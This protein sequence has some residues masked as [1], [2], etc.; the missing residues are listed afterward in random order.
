MSALRFEPVTAQ[1]HALVRAAAAVGLSQDAAP[2]RVVP[3]PR[4][5]HPR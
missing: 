4:M 5:G 2:L 3:A 1:P